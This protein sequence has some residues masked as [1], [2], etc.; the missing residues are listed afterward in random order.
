MKDNRTYY[1][2]FAGWYERERHHGYHALLDNLQLEIARPL[3]AGADALEI[4]CGTGLILQRLSEVAK[5]AVGIDISRGMLQTA[6]ERGL[7][8]LEGSATALPF[9]DASFDAVVSFKVL[10]HIEEI[11]L[12]MAEVG[13]VLKPGGRAALEFY[14]KHSLRYA[15]KRL[16]KPNAI[17]ETSN[18]EDVFTRYDTTESIAGYLPDCLK[19]KEFRGVRVLTPFAA[20]HRLPIVAPVLARLERLARDCSLTAKF[21][22]FLVVIVEKQ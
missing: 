2:D 12:A 4:G 16:K 13:R 19:I 14:N 3:V 11:E 5:S 8:T 21:G 6:H 20:V 1:D 9:A 18:D 22:G 15:I 7:K 17:S 10:A